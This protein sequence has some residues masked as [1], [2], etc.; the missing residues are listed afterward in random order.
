MWTIVGFTIAGLIICLIGSFLLV[1]EDAE[2]TATL[3]EG[4]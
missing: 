4:S 2:N 1:T 3:R